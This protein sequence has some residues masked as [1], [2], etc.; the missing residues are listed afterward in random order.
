MADDY[1]NKIPVQIISAPVLLDE[2]AGSSARYVLGYLT[3]VYETDEDITVLLFVRRNDGM[4]YEQVDSF[5]LSKTK[6]RFKRK[7][8]LVGSIIDF[9][10]K[11]DTEVKEYVITSLKVSGKALTTGKFEL[12]KANA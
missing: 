12:T 3:S 1:G 9:Y 6:K 5:L 11:L 4:V 10:I 2:E 7:I 8:K